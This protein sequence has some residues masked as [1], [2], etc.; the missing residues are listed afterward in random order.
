MIFAEDADK[1]AAFV[2]KQPETSSELQS[3]LDAI[4]D[5]PLESIGRDEAVS[6]PI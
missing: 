4:A 1:G 5:C 3:V 6:G 2:L